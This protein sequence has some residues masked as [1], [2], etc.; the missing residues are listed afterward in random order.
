MIKYQ[1]PYRILISA[2]FAVCGFIIFY[3]I[4]VLAGGM[5]QLNPDSAEN[6]DLESQAVVYLDNNGR[7]YDIWI[8]AE[9]CDFLKD[10]A[11]E[12][13]ASGSWYGFGWGDRDFF[14]NTPYAEDVKAGILFKA[15]FLPSRSVLAVQRS[16]LPPK[17]SGSVTS[18][19]VD[20]FQL[21]A[22]ADFIESCFD[23][24]SGRLR[25]VPEQL[26][27]KSYR[28]YS[29]YESLGSYSLF[30]TSNNWVNRILKKAE[31]STGLW[32]PFSF[33]VHRLED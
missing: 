30:F 2:A 20:R 14:L 10:S 11:L 12:T 3:F 31:L 29:F 26:V 4:A 18:I 16:I 8:P 25:R 28:G 27:H 24:D 13:S 5:I 6:R 15:L 9:Y 19:P 1:K 22:M 32:T 17:I 23:T 7:H 33:G 21:E